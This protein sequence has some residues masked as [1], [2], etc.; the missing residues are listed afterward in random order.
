MTARKITTEGI[1]RV[2]PWILGVRMLLSSC[3]MKRKTRAVRTAVVDD[4]K[5]A[6]MTAGIAPRKTPR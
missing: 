4:S 6:K 3:W 5:R 1:R 2:C